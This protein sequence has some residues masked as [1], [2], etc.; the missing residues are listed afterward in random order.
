MAYVTGKHSTYYGPSMT[1]LRAG[2]VCNENV[3]VLWIEGSYY[4]IEYNISGGLKKRAYV[5][6]N[7]IPSPG[8]IPSKTWRTTCDRYILSEGDVYTCQAS[9]Y[10]S[11]NTRGKK[12][13]TIAKGTRVTY[14]STEKPNGW[15]FIEFEYLNKQKVRGYYWAGY[16]GSSKPYLSTDDFRSYKQYDYIPAGYPMAG[17]SLSQGFNDKTTR[18]KGHLGYDIIGGTE[19]RAIHK[20]TVVDIRTQYSQHDGIGKAVVLEHEINGEI[21]YSNYLHLRSIGVEKGDIVYKNQRVGT[22]GD[23]GS[24]PAVHLHLAV[25][26]DHPLIIISGYCSGGKFHPYTFEETC[27]ISTYTSGKYPLYFY[28]STES[29]YEKK[30]PRCKGLRYYDPYGVI[31]TEARLISEYR[32]TLM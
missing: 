19:A 31:S 27:K 9:S 22:I 4:F 1:F 6:S 30:Y 8:T 32:N 12:I 11:H 7:A 24:E 17:Y 3:T 18:R 21:F 28:G 25:Y 10:S 14:F 13:C 2:S 20:G 29:D 16:M 15:A 26:T 23:T 5:K